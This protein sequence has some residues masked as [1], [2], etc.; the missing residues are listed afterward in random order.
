MAQENSSAVL[1]V[2]LVIYAVVALVYGIG[3]LIVPGVWVRMSE[4][5]PVDFGWLRWS[6]GVIIA[7][8]I[9][10]IMVCRK[11]DK[12]GPFVFAIAL[13]T[14]LSGIGMLI[15]L[16]FQEYS[17]TTMFIV[18]PIVLMFVISGLL[19]WGRQQAKDIL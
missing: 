12:Q 4:G 14:L 1:K 6:G 18:I 15:S 2:A 3:F 5:A 16:I 17:G 9:A 10:A 13:A 19:W 11:P 7:F 8:G